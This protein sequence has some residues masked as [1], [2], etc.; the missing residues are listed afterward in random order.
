MEKVIFFLKLGTFHR[1]HVPIDCNS[2]SKIANARFTWLGKIGLA[3]SCSFIFI[4]DWVP[5]KQT[6]G[7][8]CGRFIGEFLQ[9]LDLGGSEEGRIGQ[10]RHGTAVCL[11]QR[12][13][14]I[15]WEMEGWGALAELS[16]IVSRHQPVAAGCHLGQ[17]CDLRGSS[18]PELGEIPS[19]RYCPELGAGSSQDSWQHVL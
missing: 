9:E 15:L 11:Q 2:F 10:G 12:P 14:P 8:T 1:K 4:L 6:L 7:I 13:L 3:H 17:G 18:S 16:W 5:F 19:E